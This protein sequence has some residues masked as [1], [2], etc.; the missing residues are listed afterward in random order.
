MVRT[1]HPEK[2]PAESSASVV[3]RERAGEAIPENRQCP[4]FELRMRHWRLSPSS[5][6]A[7]M[8]SSSDQKALSNLARSSSASARSLSPLGLRPRSSAAAAILDFAAYAYDCTSH[9]A[10]GPLARLPS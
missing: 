3:Q 5:A 1:P 2:S 8:E 9:K 10:I 7:N 6:M 4:A